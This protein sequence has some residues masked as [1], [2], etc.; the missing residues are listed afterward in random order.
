ML[1][2]EMLSAID[3]R[4]S[5][6]SG[7]QSAADIVAASLSR[8]R[9]LDSDIRA[10]ISVCDSA[11][12]QAAAI[13]SKR[14]SG[15]S[16]GALAGVPVVVKDNMQLLGTTTTAGSK[17]LEN[18][19]SQFTATAVQKL[20]DADA[21]IIGKSNLDEFAMGSS[22]ENSGFFCTRNPRDMSR[23]PG[24]SSG[25]SAAAVAAGYAPVSLGSDTGGSIRQPASFCGVVGLKPTYG[26]V[27]R[28]GLLAYGSSLDQIGP[29]AR[30][31]NDAALV[32]SVISGPDAKDSTTSPKPMPDYLSGLKPS[33]D[34]SLKGVRIGKPVEY[35]AEGLNEDV[36]RSIE[37][38]LS[39]FESLG[40]TIVDVR[41]PHSNY[42]IAAYY[43]IAM[44]EASSNLARYDG[45]HYGYRSPDATAIEAVFSRSRRE[46]LG[47]EVKRRIMLGAYAL[48]SGYYD[49]YYLKAQKVRTLI[50]RDFDT[51][52][53]TCDMI[54]GPT[55]PTT[56][57]KLGEMTADPL[58]M[59]LSDIYTIS[60][61]LAALPAISVP[62][63]NDRNNLPV[64]LQLIGKPFDELTLFKTAR[65]VE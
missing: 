39:R 31:V 26:R 2:I 5:V 7:D 3:I 34:G 28:Y 25:G 27:S 9:A 35:F 12:E 57:F 45:V 17:M 52:F 23:A 50:K 43:I 40:A 49:A 19:Q 64:G 21:V 20:I 47:A 1:P 48:S 51:A 59:Y 11:A 32:L 24:G 58:A 44:S 65:A 13:D 15:K 29:F 56:A 63:G 54:A 61:N 60:V 36:R 37:A 14:A 8:V 30:N 16:L 46:A 53:E 22:T 38:T 4:D 62:C 42:A 10:M 18:Y 41:L 6:R 33:S 55:A